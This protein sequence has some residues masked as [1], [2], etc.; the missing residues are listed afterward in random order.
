MLTT[1]YS[2]YLLC[3]RTVDDRAL[4]RHV[5]GRLRQELASPRR[6]PLRVF[7]IGGGLGTMVARLVDW[8]LVKRA[9]YHLL[10]VD[11]QLLADARAWLASW[12]K[13]RGLACRVEAGSVRLQGEP[14]IDVTVRFVCAEIGDFLG[15]SA[16]LPRADLLVANAFLDLVDVPAILPRL[17]GLPADGGLAWF[18]VNFDGDTILEPEHPDDALFLR[19]YHRSM[20]ER[21]RHGRPAG[22]SRS[23][24]HLFAHLRNA[25]ASLLAAGASDWVVHAQPM[26][27]PDDEAQFLRQIVDTITAEL[28]QHPEIPPAG[29]AAWADLRRRQID[30]AELVYIAHQI[31]FLGRGP[32]VEPG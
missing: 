23:G 11:A 17:F 13:A 8:N 12:A 28:A 24:R 5:L 20:D 19:V 26:G 32:R 9:E 21:V 3:K 16:T 27:Y 25:G 7:E 1:P 30:H 4:N 29:L 22:D 31:D 6:E 10:D 18:T 15:D 2:R 14:D